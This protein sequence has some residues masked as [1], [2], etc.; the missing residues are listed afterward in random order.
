M[1]FPFFI[2]IIL[3]VY[4]LANYYVFHRIWVAMPPNTILRVILIS[5]AIITSLGWIAAAAFGDSMPIPI[6]SVLYTI[7]T[8]W[9]FIVIYFVLVFLFQDLVLLLNKVTNVVPAK[10]I[11]QFSKEN[12]LGMLFT[13]GFVA[14]LMIGGYLRYTWKTRVELPI[15][16]SKNI[17]SDSI[18]NKP[19]RIVG[20][21]DLH[22]GYTIGKSELR[23][24]VDLINKENPDIILIAGDLVDGS[25]RPVLDEDMTRV[26]RT[27]KAP[28]GVY[29]CLGNHELL[30]GNKGSQLADFFK[31]SN[32]KLLVDEHVEIDSA[33]YIIGRNDKTYKNRKDLSE[34]VANLDK[35]K[36]MILLDHQPYNLEQVEENGIDFQLSGHTHKGQI[37]PISMITNYLYEIDHGYLQKGN[38]HIYVSSGLG[39]W[40]GKF[41]IGTQSEFVVIDLK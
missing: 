25:L 36:P 33:L 17:V 26:L 18:S 21:T 22:L 35:S 11:L 14:M 6:T 19:L 41:R 31:D 13:I 32:I 3:A 4:L 5:V 40:G 7:G 10:V 39:I 29:A 9:M 30:G 15:E 24:W 27:L 12:W 8:S 34:L 2:F 20:I 37:W 38:S 23:K 1:K 16:L 28:K